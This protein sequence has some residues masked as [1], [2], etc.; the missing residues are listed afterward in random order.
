MQRQEKGTSPPYSN[1]DIST[2]VPPAF[3]Q[4]SPYA[5]DTIDA[6]PE[7]LAP[8]DL[9]Y[10]PA[11][12]LFLPP[13]Q[14]AASSHEA[15]AAVY[16]PIVPP[17]GT[18]VA[19]S[20]GSSTSTPVSYHAATRTNFSPPA[21]GARAP[22]DSNLSTPFLGAM[23]ASDS[24]LA[25][26]MLYAS[27]Q[28]RHRFM[29][30]VLGIIILQLLLTAA[31]AAPVVHNKQ[32][33]QFLKQNP[34]ALVLSSVVAFTVVIILACSEAARR[35]HPTNLILLS[36]FTVTEG[37]LVGVA[38]ATYNTHVLLNALVWTAA[39]MLIMVVYALQTR[40]DFTSEGG[41]LYAALTILLLVSLARLVFHVKMLDALLSGCGAL[42]F[43]AY[44]VFDI[45][46]TASGDRFG[47]M[48]SPD[49]YVF[50]ALNI[51]TDVISV[52][53]YVLRLIQGLQPDLE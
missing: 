36:V 23:S 20:W 6:A 3:P 51:Y 29:R 15:A 21:A 40:V 37:L 50:A 39:A 9:F 35:T 31:V 46:L 44:F 17:I 24:L 18:T 5:S 33:R 28:V 26:D 53:L 41:T 14:A 47:S 34:W 4:S 13:G 2:L 27:R 10:P 12:T 30:K 45:H 22:L 1:D 16:F 11:S 49:E 38:S 7:T 19:P 42:L 32:V 52:F 8:P 43:S 25:Y 48:I